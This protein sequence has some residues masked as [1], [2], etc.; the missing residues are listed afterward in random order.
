MTDRELLEQ[1]LQGVQRMEKRIDRLE[2]RFDGL[3]SRFDGLETRFDGLETRFDGL[4]SKFDLMQKDQEQMKNDIKNINL[5]LENEIEKHLSILAENH[6]DLIRKMNENNKVSEDTILYKIKVDR[7]E[8]KYRSLA[9]DVY[10]L[11]NQAQY[12]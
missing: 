7:L 2:S 10:V 11:K 4:E 1:V 8:R 9:M 6:I 3:E 12:A 5:R